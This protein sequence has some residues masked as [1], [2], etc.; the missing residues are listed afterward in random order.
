MSKRS[1]QRKIFNEFKKKKEKELKL[2]TLEKY[3]QIHQMYLDGEVT[4]QEGYNHCMSE[5]LNIEGYKSRGTKGYLDSTKIKKPLEN[6]SNQV[7]YGRNDIQENPN[8]NISFDEVNKMN[9]TEFKEFILLVRNELLHNWDE[10]NTPPYIGKD[11]NGIVE[12]IKGLINFDIGKLGKNGDDTYKYVISNDYKLGSSCNQFQPSLHKTR[13]GNKSMYDVIK[14]PSLEL[15]WI[16]TFTR[17][18]KQ[19][20]MYMVSK[21]FKNKNDYKEIDIEQYAFI[22]QIVKE[23][24]DISFS[25]KEIKDLHKKGVIKD[26]HITNLGREFHDYENFSIRYFKRNEKIV[27]HIIHILRVGFANIPI[28][29]S[30]LVSRFL[31]EKYLLNK[32]SVVYDPCSGWGGR[33]L[34]SITSKKDITYI[35]C[36]VN[37][38]IFKT[39][40][41]ERIGEFVEKEIGIK[42]N[43]KVHQISSTE[44]N[45][46]DDYKKY[47]GKV[48]MIL[49]SPPY[50]NLERYSTDKEQSYNLFPSYEKWINGYIKQ[51]FQIGYELL[52]KNGVLLLNI[53][54]TKEFPLELDTLGVLEKI[55]FK[56]QYEIGMKMQRYIGLNTKKIYNRYY[57]ED[58]GK[59]VKVEPIMVYIK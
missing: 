59:W 23:K 51:T 54:D 42:S 57:D 35:G 34:G 29:F 37:S 38:E 21:N 3:P 32:K 5:L 16:R 41:Y 50:F 44:F 7:P 43:Y 22:L 56:F 8:I 10:K 45:K 46:T 39:R 20:K 2:K 49:T 27:K 30:P 26:Y 40:S 33:L 18:L 1:E 14:E 52:K 9:Y 12:D 13:I 15:L 6:S 55:G 58:K 17:N 25:K 19:D 47:K 36:D 48:D 31:Y 11:K 24:N 53:S 4:L 28:N